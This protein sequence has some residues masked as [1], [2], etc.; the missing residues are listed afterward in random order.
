LPYPVEV[1]NQSDVVG[2]DYGTA[3]VIRAAAER[4]GDQPFIL[5]N[6]DM[7]YSDSILTAVR[8]D[9]YTHVLT[10]FVEDPR[11][12]GVVGVDTNGF[13]REIV[14]KPAE[15]QSQMINLGLYVCQP[16]VIAAA[17]VVERSPRGEFEFVDAINSLAERR[18]VKADCVTGEWVTLTQQEDI[19]I[20]ER[21]LRSH[22]RV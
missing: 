5:Y 1:I 3:V 17:N 6:G 12:Y 16:E 22:K 7:L 10:T 15:P 4:I 8:D 21:F 11:P 20:I 18:R 14:E 19:P 9:G 2:T 13:V